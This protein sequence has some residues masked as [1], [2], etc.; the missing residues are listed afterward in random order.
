MTIGEA[1][2]QTRIAEGLTQQSLSILSGFSER[3]IN[4][5]EREKKVPKLQ[6]LK[7]VAEA[8]GRDMVITYSV[9]KKILSIE[10]LVNDGIRLKSFD[11]RVT[12]NAIQAKLH[13]FCLRLCE[14]NK[15]NANDLVQ[16][17]TMNALI[18]HHR[19]NE[20]SCQLITWLCGIA[21]NIHYRNKKKLNKL[22]YVED[23]IETGIVNEPEG[24]E[25]PTKAYQFINKL[26]DKRKKLYKLRL[27]GYKYGEIAKELGTT[28]LYVKSRF[29]QVRKELTDLITN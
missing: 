24:E 9:T 22:T 5:W 6:S 28:E 21:K 15:D 8:F 25:A 29:F 16:E 3:S 19:W 7:L 27:A 2:K 1:I 23:Y 13:H 20:A 10:F 11:E 12:N 18:Y 14:Y 17:T 26:S 4:N